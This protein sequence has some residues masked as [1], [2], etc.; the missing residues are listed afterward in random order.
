MPSA[1]P[2][3]TASSNGTQVDLAQRALVDHRVDRVALELGVVAGEVLHRRGDALRLHAAHERGRDLAREQR[4]LGVA[5]EVAARERRAVDVDR[6]REQHAARL[7]ARLLAEH[8]ADPL[9]E[10]D[11]PR[12]AERGAARHARRRCSRRAPGTRAPARAVGPVGDPDLGM[13]ARSTAGVDKRSSPA[14]RSAFSSSVSDATSASSSVVVLLTSGSRSG[15]G[16][17]A[18]PVVWGESLPIAKAR[19]DRRP[20][21]PAALARSSSTP[22]ASWWGFANYS[23]HGDVVTFVHTEIDEQHEGHGYAGTLV[24]AA[25]RRR[26]DPWLTVIAQCPYVSRYIRV[27]RRVRRP[28]DRLNPERMVV[29]PGQLLRLDLFA[30]CAAGDLDALAASLE[31]VHVEPGTVLMRQGEAADG[32]VLIVAGSASVHRTEDGVER[33]IGAAGVG[34]IIG[35][36]AAVAGLAPGATVVAREARRVSSATSPPSGRCSTHP[37]WPLRS[38]APVGPARRPGAPGRGRA[39]R[40]HPAVAAADPPVRPRVHR[41]G[42]RA[43]RTRIATGASSPTRRSASA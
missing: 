31:P 33:E 19:R 16:R 7:G 5:L 32:F 29:D 1:P 27:P 28:P 38:P 14:V 41:R 39:A 8:R 4:V 2:S 43:C 9:D 40:R 12:R 3:R 42:R 10:L 11:V 17:R 23:R 21:Q 25:G 37:G 24:A 22:T 26:A 15:S 13:P 30:G 18:P 36:L 34:S 6:R 35:E 20:R